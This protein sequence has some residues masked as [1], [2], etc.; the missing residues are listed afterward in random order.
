MCLG[1]TERCPRSLPIG[2]P[3]CQWSHWPVNSRLLY[4][5]HLKSSVEN[6]T[7]HHSNSTHNLLSLPWPFP[8]TVAKSLL[9][10]V[11]W[12]I[13]GNLHASA[14]R[15]QFSGI[16]SSLLPDGPGDWTQL[17]RL[18]SKCLNPQSHLPSLLNFPSCPIQSTI[19]SYSLYPQP[20]SRYIFFLI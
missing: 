16:S 6:L 15:G 13:T 9:G 19:K 11:E 12:Q 2:K 20:Y 10:R 7:E 4:K 3:K 17:V 1:T 14:F 8:S 5:G 18:G